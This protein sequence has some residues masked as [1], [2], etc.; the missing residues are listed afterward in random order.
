MT[1]VGLTS[2][3]EVL[4]GVLRELLE[5]KGKKSIDILC[6]SARLANRATTVGEADVDGL[7]KED[8]GS[9]GIPGVGIIDGLDVLADRA[10]AELKEKAGQRRASWT[11]VQPEDD[12]VSLGVISGLKEP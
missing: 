9:V 10:G 4:V 2:N 5:E 7:V 1:S 8:N 3:V 6:C 12:G 11:T